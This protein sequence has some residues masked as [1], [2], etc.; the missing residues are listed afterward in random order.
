MQFVAD[1]VEEEDENIWLACSNN[2]LT[3][4]QYFL[5]QGSRPIITYY[6]FIHTFIHPLTHSLID[7]LA[8]SLT[9]S[10]THALAHLLFHLLTYLGI[11]VNVQDEHGYAP[12]HAAVSW[13]NL[14]IVQFLLQSGANIHI[15]DVEGDQNSLK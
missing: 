3:K 8:H 12:L 6:S 2:N 13:N 9:D 7:L 15:K 4:I 5:S 10:L 14:E 11:N 1:S